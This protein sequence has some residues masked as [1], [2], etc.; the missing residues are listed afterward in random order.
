MWSRG[1]A[2]VCFVLCLGVTPPAKAWTSARVRDVRAEIDVAR[3]GSATVLLDVGVEVLGGWLERLD[4]EGLDEELV[5]DEH[6]PAW[7]T[8]AEGG[9]VPASAEAE[10]G[11]ITLRFDKRS[12]ARRGLH[13]VH[14][15]YIAPLLRRPAADDP[16]RVELPWT[17]PGW[18]HGLTQAQILVR[19]PAGLRL[20]RDPE[21][22]LEVHERVEGGR[23]VIEL[24]RVLVPRSTAWTLTLEGKASLFGDAQASGPTDK[25]NAAPTQGS[26]FAGVW[27]ALLVLG[28][29]FLSRRSFRLRAS[30]AGAV[31]RPWLSSTRQRRGLLV[32]G[33]SIACLAGPW[34]ALWMVAA[35]LGL[36]LCFVDTVQAEVLP[37][38]LG[39]FAPLS[40]GDRQRL[41]RAQ[42]KA[43]LGT[44]PWA[45][46]ATLLGAF[47]ALG[48][49]TASVFVARS[50]RTLGLG[51]LCALTCFAASSRLRLPRPL[52]AQVAL[53]LSAA[54]RSL[55][56]SCAMRPLA[57]ST[58]DGQLS[59]PRL[60]IVPAA[61]FTGL[62]RLDVGVD[63]RRGQ[64]ALVLIA[65]TQAGSGAD[66]AL[67]ARGDAFVRE[68]SPQ[69]HRAAHIQ[70]I[71]ELG[72]ALE[73]VLSCL[74]EH[75]QLTVE[76]MDAQKAA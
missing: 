69:G 61:R 5:L 39:R 11:A 59:S 57:F 20:V 51:L 73:A 36:T 64:P 2:A 29:G 52:Y 21:L 28:L 31:A 34:S 60:R 18:E 26:R 35:L 43:W 6:E 3:D 56:L 24:T 16:S 71:E 40:L 37:I 62:L 19:G 15:R 22:G 1:L 53:L 9:R 54:E 42:L 41:R 50:D 58:G 33:C 25:P 8:T 30:Q 72:A 32:V 45:D 44:A 70:P 74:A 17:L 7:L 10:A 65:M 4:L 38:P 14:V 68:L 75:S 48:L 55:A 12:A 47:S 76:R 63:R 13:R 49:L 23:S 46:G 67:S 66:Q 27:S